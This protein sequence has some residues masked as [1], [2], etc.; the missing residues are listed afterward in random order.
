M[1]GINFDNVQRTES[2]DIE[3][4]GAEGY[5]DNDTFLAEESDDGF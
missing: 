5:V 4:Y 1:Q 2:I 3:G